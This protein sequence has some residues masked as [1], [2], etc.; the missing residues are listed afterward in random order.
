MS[1]TLHGLKEL[2]EL[3]GKITTL[4]SLLVDVCLEFRGRTRE[5]TLSEPLGLRRLSCATI[6]AHTALRKS[7]EQSISRGRS[8]QCETSWFS[9]TESGASWKIPPAMISLGDGLPKEC[10]ALSCLAIAGQNL[11]DSH[12]ML[13]S[14]DSK[15]SSAGRALYGRGELRRGAVQPFVK[16]ISL[17]PL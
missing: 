1:D 16:L 4:I 15:V 9:S 2:S 13:L 12:L 17:R 5:S 7:K 8:L 10:T 6:T 3:L 11:L 14:Q